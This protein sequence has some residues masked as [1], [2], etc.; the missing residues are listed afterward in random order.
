MTRF[1]LGPGGLCGRH[2]GRAASR[3]FFLK[4]SAAYAASAA[5]SLNLPKARAQGLRSDGLPRLDGEFLT[6][7][8]ARRSVAADYGVSV[9]R[10]PLAVVR[11][12]TIEDVVRVVSHANTRGLRVV[13]RG[14]AHSLSGQA[15]VENG[16]VIDSSPLKEIRMVS[17]EVLDA[18]PGALWG[19]VGRV[20]FVH[21]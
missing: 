6:Q 19:D 11:P 12:K 16:I 21:R 4:S 10:M 20:A 15:L 13:M 1:A 14:Q 2:S 9:Q 18:Q 7:D 17:N 5:L 3:R 8:A